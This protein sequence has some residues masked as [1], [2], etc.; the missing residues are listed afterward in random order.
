[1]NDYGQVNTV[2]VDRTVSAF[3]T[4]FDGSSSPVQV[5]LTK[6]GRNIITFGRV[7]ANDI[8]IRSQFV[9]R[10]H[11]MFK[12]ENGHFI[13]EDLGSTNG[14]IFNSQRVKSH[15]LNDNDAIRIDSDVDSQN[16]VLIVF[17]RKTEEGSWKTL[18]LAGKSEFYIGRD[19]G[20][21]IT[22][23][24]IGVSRVHTKIFC[25]NGQFYISDNNSTNG[26]YVNGQRLSGS[27]PLHE[28]DLILITNSK[29][30]YSA[31]KLN[32]CTFNQGIGV[33]ATRI[34]KVVDNGRKTICNNV[35]LNIQPCELVAFVGG[36]GAGKS[37]LM[38][39][40]SGYSIPTSGSVK[41]N[42]MDLYS[43]LDTLKN[44]I[45]Y[46]PQQDIVFENL[47][48]YNML[49]YTADLRLPQ[50]T[51][52]KEKDAVIM[53]V[54][55]AV[56]LT[57][58]KDTMIKRLSGGQKKRASIAVELISDPNLFFLDEPCSGLDP[59][60]ERNLM[61]TLKNM[62]KAGKT[63]IFVTHSTLNLHLCDK[64]VF[65]GTGGKLCFCGNY[66]EALAFF[67]V[68][69]L[70]DVY[71]MISSDP[72]TWR[73]KYN[74]TGSNMNAPAYT[75]QKTPR[76]RQNQGMA[77]QMFILARRHLRIMF[78][79]TGRLL[80]ILLQA[81][82]LALL[83]SLVADKNTVF[84][85]QGA[86]KSILFSLACCA[87]WIGLLNSI[88]EVCKERNILKREYMTGLRL[89][90]YILSKLFVMGIV[91]LIQSLLLSGVFAI[92][93]G[94][95]DKAISM[96]SSFV[97][98]AVITFLTAFAA[99]SMGLFVSSVV[100]NADKAMTI[101]PILLMPQLLFSGIVFK[102][103]GAAEIVSYLTACRFS[104][105]AYGTVANINALESSIPGF[106]PET[107]DAFTYKISH[108]GTSL[109]LLGVF[110][111]VFAIL[112]A[113]V[114]KNIKNENR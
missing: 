108:F 89:D 37:T 114:L 29:I 22:L 93:V 104:V 18:Q 87:F 33:S 2:P 90:S 109:L 43:N 51:T 59:G 112:A 11:G 31:G 66:Q 55:A 105:E 113:V 30:I 94:L 97:E 41:V 38:N 68:N 58:H 107:S 96:G 85:V 103:E 14:L 39:C 46:V 24:H 53:K 16:G 101:A 1:M 95:P 26:T 71:N 47:T 82:L 70:V 74:A 106:P 32:F 102:L 63:V 76:P 45:G 40:I 25:K 88:Q 36:S 10:Q 19:P 91:C 72:D 80:L 21:D 12:Y 77:S 42:G 92:T 17:S 99:S 62:T 110:V 5:D 6:F 23:N 98:Y 111:V 56:E 7:D 81:P 35:S 69:D 9:S 79:D 15:I 48:V 34:S 100:T 8:V 84:E 28:K 50:D 57:A 3:I 64:I 20:C 73:N 83:I 13:I 65:M 27:R 44:I 61:H 78:N 86:T 49:S 4:I 52:K 75:S 60:T 54:I 67:G